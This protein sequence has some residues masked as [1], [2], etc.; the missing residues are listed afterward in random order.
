MV[1]QFQYDV[2]ISYSQKDRVA[3]EDLQEALKER[4]LKVWRDERITDSASSSFVSTIN[5]SLERSAKVIV[6][7]SRRSLASV[8]VLSEAERARLLERVVPLAL[9]PLDALLPFIPAPFNILPAFDVTNEGFDLDVLLRAMGAKPVAGAAPGI[10]SLTTAAVDL[11]KL[12]STFAD[13]LYGR[14]REMAALI[15]A[16]DGGQT[17]I[18][19]FDAIGGA[20]KTA[21]A[22]HFVQ[23]LKATGW[24]GARR[25]FAW[26]FDGQGSNEDRQKSADDFFKAATHFFSGYTA[27]PPSDPREKGVFLAKLVQENRALLI[28]DGME[29][30]Q[31]ANDHAGRPGPSE[32]GGLH[33]PGMKALLSML[34]EDN[35]GLCLV[36]T[37][38]ALADL[39]GAPGVQFEPL[40]RLPLMDGVALIR[41]LGVEPAL[42][43]KLYKLPEPDA[44]IV[45]EPEWE[46]PAA[47]AVDTRDDRMPMHVRDAKKLIEAVE[48]LGGHALALTLAAKYLVEHHNGDVR[49]IAELP[50]LPDLD[51]SDPHRN[52][53]RVMRA[54]EIALV[55][56]IEEQGR[57]ETPANAI[58]G[59]ELAL[60]LF[61]GFFD[62][63]AG[64]ALLPVVFPAKGTPKVTADDLMVAATE[65]ERVPDESVLPEVQQRKR[66]AVRSARRRI[67]FRRAFAGM[68][69]ISHGELRAVLSALAAR[70]LVAK[71]DDEADWQ[72]TAIDCHPLVRAYFAARLKELDLAAFQA[73]HGRLY[74][75]YRY[76]G[77]PEAFREPVAYGSLVL[78]ATFPDAPIKDFVLKLADGKLGKDEAAHWPPSLTSAR[79]AQVRAAAT[80]LIGGSVW[81]RTVADFL[82]MTEA[83]M[84][85]LFRA[86]GHGCA[87]GQDRSALIEVFLPRVS[88]GAARYSVSHLGLIGPTLEAAGTFFDVAYVEP[89][90]TL[91]HGLHKLALDEADFLL[92]AQRAEAP[93]APKVVEV[94]GHIEPLDDGLDTLTRA[95]T[96]LCAAETSGLAAAVALSADA[97]AAIRKGNQEQFLPTALLTCAEADWQAGDLVG[98]DAHLREC[99]TLCKQ[100]PMALFACD[101]A[102]LK[103]RMQLAANRPARALKYRNEAAALAK[104]HDY[105]R[106]LPEIAVLD[107]EI[108]AAEGAPELASRIDAAVMAIQGT[109]YRD[110]ATGQTIDGGWRDLS[111][112]LGLVM[113]QGHP[114]LA[115]L[116]AA[117]DACNAERDEYRAMPESGGETFVAAT[118][119]AAT[120]AFAGTDTLEVSDDLLDEVLADPELRGQL[121]EMLLDAAIHEPLD[122]LPRET[123]REAVSALLAA[124]ED[125][126]ETDGVAEVAAADVAPA[127]AP[128]PA[129]RPTPVVA[130]SDAVVH[131]VFADPKSHDMLK[132]VMRE[133]DLLGQPGDL[134]FDT[135]REIVE[136]L[137]EHGRI[138]V[139]KTEYL[140]SQAPQPV[141]V[142]IPVLVSTSLAPVAPAGEQ[143]DAGMS[144]GG[145]GGWGWW[146]FKEKA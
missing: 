26:S 12:P 65:Y 143:P 42:A 1:A 109:A 126:P 92:R 131:Y 89:S 3:A 113:P 71:V 76:Q 95:R 128:M 48:E 82:P 118:A 136:V 50:A 52:P 132:K 117:R 120:A 142:A 78:A 4:G 67:L 110:V 18:F 5:G 133:A 99:D 127:P 15:Q 134:E 97:L 19:A 32:V 28:L 63:P 96:L 111:P 81:D 46:P 121:E 115:A 68:H 83:R 122:M 74:D 90:K 2:F 114:A 49:A 34:A 14:D 103:A 87:A 53:Y 61:L 102:L 70:G 145:K 130:V 91:P 116:H 36:T 10:V 77:L 8:W 7:W 69:A 37:R 54:I 100:G 58:A 62:R 43:P 59:R 27:E 106:A 30:L 107:A 146:P 22:Y 9:E 11:T 144:A 29:P 44:F 72:K 47:Y 140:A 85:P 84:A 25:V 64:T 16:W 38:I 13:K 124:M 119:A 94:P 79:P 21:L 33:D 135:R 60:L 105:G 41:D 80:N 39:T 24:R 55:K 51:P 40:D 141:P 23:A 108:A 45:L 66:E 129:P 104:G 112:R 88:R 139:I 138:D 20:G 86:I 56:R 35:P 123:Q 75:H 17:R 101:S 73:G 57:S 137:A 6:L 125:M 93:I 31:F 98:A